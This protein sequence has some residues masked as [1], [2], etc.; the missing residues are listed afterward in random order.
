MVRILKKGNDNFTSRFSLFGYLSCLFVKIWL[1]P[2]PNN[3]HQLSDKSYCLKCAMKNGHIICPLSNG[4]A[5][6]SS[7]CL[8]S[9]EEELSIA[10]CVCTLLKVGSLGTWSVN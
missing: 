5:K 8:P 4:G 7:Q 1:L 9:F 2:L 3:R 10:G 6:L